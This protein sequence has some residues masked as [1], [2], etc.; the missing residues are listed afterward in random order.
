M[1][2]QDTP[3]SFDDFDELA[4]QMF[5]QACD[6]STQTSIPLGAVLAGVIFHLAV[7]A[8]LNEVPAQMLHLVI[9][10]AQDAMDR[11]ERDAAQAE[12]VQ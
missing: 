8:Q 5:E 1:S 4:E 9:G 11:Y 6:H 2:T 7:E 12:A 3:L 10:Q